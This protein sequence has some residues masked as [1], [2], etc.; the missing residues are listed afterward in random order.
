MLQ[1][2]CHLTVYQISLQRMANVP[3]VHMFEEGPCKADQQTDLWQNISHVFG[4]TLVIRSHGH[5]CSA[6]RADVH[7]LSCTSPVHLINTI[8]NTSKKGRE[9]SLLTIWGIKSCRMIFY[10]FYNLSLKMTKYSTMIS[11]CTTLIW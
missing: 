9:Q 1:Q 10:G 8:V 2:L 4:N 6:Y 11:S 5:H 7:L 3:Q